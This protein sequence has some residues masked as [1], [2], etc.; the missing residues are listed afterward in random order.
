[1]LRLGQ[2][3][4][5]VVGVLSGWAGDCAGGSGKKQP[6][7]GAHQGR[8]NDLTGRG[9][10]RTFVLWWCANAVVVGTYLYFTEK[11]GGL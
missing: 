11:T 7:V 3:V 8:R 2:R 6:M 4:V 1:M 5:Q 9:D 10:R